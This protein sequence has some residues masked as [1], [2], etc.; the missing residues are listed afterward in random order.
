MSAW[1]DA[2]EFNFYFTDDVAAA[3]LRIDNVDCVTFLLLIKPTR[4]LD[5]DD[6]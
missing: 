3:E 6:G 5:C 2:P 1:A 4:A